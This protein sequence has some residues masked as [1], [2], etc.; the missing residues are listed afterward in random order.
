[1]C[2]RRLLLAACLALGLGQVLGFSEAAQAAPVIPAAGMIG[3]QVH[4][5]PSSSAGVA[6]GI[7]GTGIIGVGTT[8]AGIIGG[9]GAATGGTAATITIIIT[10]LIMPAAAAG[11]IPAAIDDP[12]SCRSKAYLD[13]R[14]GVTG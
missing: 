5:A 6:T 14:P 4:P 1:M 11:S 7:A 10:G 3:Q 12:P 2:V 13:G 9:T 8:G